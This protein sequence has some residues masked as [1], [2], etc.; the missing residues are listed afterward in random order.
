MIENMK[1]ALVVLQRDSS[2]LFKQVRE[3]LSLADV[4]RLP[5]NSKFDEFTETRR[6]RV[7]Y[8]FSVAKC[9]KYWVRIEN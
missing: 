8:S 5:L 2:A 7:Q 6:I 3:K 4:A 1:R 9:L